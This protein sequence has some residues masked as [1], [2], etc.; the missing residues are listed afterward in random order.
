MM[1]LSL[2]FRF[3][4]KAWL[5]KK[6]RCVDAFPKVLPTHSLATSSIEVI[7]NPYAFVRV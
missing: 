4:F 6:A 1:S 7:L 2:Q 5:I 3:L